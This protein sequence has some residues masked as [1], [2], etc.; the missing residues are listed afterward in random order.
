MIHELC[1]TVKTAVVHGQMEGSKLEDVMID[2]INGDYGVLIAT[3]I[4]ENGLDIPNANTIIINNAHHF[5]LSD[6]HQ[7]RG[8]VGRS[9]KK[10]FCYILSPPVSGLTNEA[11]KRLKAIEEYSELGSGFN[12]ALQDMDIRGAG[13]MLGSE[14][15]GFIADIGF[16][17]YHKILNEAIHELKE[18]EFKDV[19][20]DQTDTP[21]LTHFENT[22]ECMI[23][24][25]MELLIPDSYVSNIAERIKLYRQLDSTDTEEQLAR[26]TDQLIDRF[27]PLPIQTSE[28]SEVVR[29]RWRAN[30]L[31]IEKIVLKNKL[32]ICYFTGDYNS[33]YYQTEIFKGI[34]NFIQKN[35]DKCRMKEGNNKLSLT[36]YEVKNI[37]KALM[38][39]DKII[40]SISSLIP[41]H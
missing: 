7:L 27:G 8:R 15:S 38:I 23:D 35:P 25:D 13:N 31:G 30:K 1:P 21:G 10:A 19:F 41:S 3:S 14:Q 20:S 36:F 33:E 29:L 6:L 2:F 26:F 11:R 22:T 17:T 18:N 4:I 28:L 37:E 24:T 32:M 34:L 12:I 5:G 39:T 16:E 9:N 40:L